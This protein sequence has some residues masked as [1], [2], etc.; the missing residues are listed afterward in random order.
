[1][2]LAVDNN[3]VSETTAVDCDLVEGNL[4]VNKHIHVKR[5]M[6]KKKRKFGKGAKRGGDQKRGSCWPSTVGHVHVAQEPTTADV[7][8]ASLTVPMK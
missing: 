8:A 1:V 5:K 7:H 3:Q 6:P 2:D 4:A